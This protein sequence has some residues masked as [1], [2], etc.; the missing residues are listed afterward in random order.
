MT[1]LQSR[2]MDAAAEAGVHMSRTEKTQPFHVR[3]WD[4]TLTRIA[5]HDHTDGICDL[6]TDYR[7]DLS[8]V[9]AGDYGRSGSCHWTM[10]FTGTMACCCGMCHDA[11]GLRAKRRA[12]RHRVRRELLD[13]VKV[14]NHDWRYVI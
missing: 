4:G 11:D 8:C 1:Y 5:V 7:E 6:P 10:H 3:L 2:G 14:A 9:A 12:D 13:L